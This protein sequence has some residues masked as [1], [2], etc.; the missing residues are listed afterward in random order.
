MYFPYEKECDLSTLPVTDMPLRTVGK[1]RAELR[2]KETA[3]RISFRQE[4]AGT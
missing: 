4:A 3:C 1:S 2:G